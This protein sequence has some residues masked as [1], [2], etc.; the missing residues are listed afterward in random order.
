M[1]S[2]WKPRSLRDSARAVMDIGVIITIGVVFAALMVIAF[3][4]YTM[5]DS[6]LKSTPYGA[7]VAQD[8]AYN[9]TKSSLNNIT[10][11]FDSAVKLLLIAITVAILSIAL[12]YLLMLRHNG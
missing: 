1:E 6:L 4:I 7:T 8:V 3:I 12:G 10:V 11:G 9:T 5:K 2:M